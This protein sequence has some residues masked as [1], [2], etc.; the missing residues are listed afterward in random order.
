MAANARGTSSGA[1]DQGTS[2]FTNQLS[3]LGKGGLPGVSTDL[4]QIGFDAT[5]EVDVFGGQRRNLEAAGA[6]LAASVESRRD[7]VITLLA[8]VARNYLELR[9]AQQRLGVARE[10]LQAGN[11]ILDLTRSIQKSGLTT[12][13]DV[14][15]S[16]GQVATVA[17][18]VP[19]L[20]GQ[21]RR[22]MHALAT[23]LNEDPDALTAEL[24]DAQPVPPL[25]PEVPVGLP[26]DL[27]KRRPDIRRAEQQIAAA[28]ARVGVA[29]ADLFPK[30]GL[31]GSVGLDA[32]EF[33]K[34]FN[35]ESRYFLISP[36]ITWPVFDA[37]RIVSN[38]SLQKSIAAEARLQYRRAVL[39]ALQDVEDALINYAT[40]QARNKAL[41]DSLQQNRD[42]LDIARQQYQQG[43]SPFLNV[44]DAERNL[45][46]AQDAVA[47]SDLQ[48]ATNL[49]AL[50]KSLGGG[51]QIEQQR[52]IGTGKSVADVHD[53]D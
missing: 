23:L 53:G 1:G 16:A 36:T 34:L 11:E 22:S 46:S 12:D 41:H 14:A 37:G 40:E 5:W 25:P 10:N 9:G 13:L 39:V 43:L 45:F 33:T 6:D 44:L 8:E 30:F 18:T 42:A 2:P 19:P 17:A 35:W 50:Y 27:L 38:I 4:Y 51:W 32:T 20:E 52:A 7:T 47:Q 24:K 29:E 31:T 49:V 48:M 26:S 3:P 21:V 28:T 15:R